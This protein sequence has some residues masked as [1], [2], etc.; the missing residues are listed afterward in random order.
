MDIRLIY[1]SQTGNTRKV[2]EAMEHVFI[3]AGHSARSV[4]MKQ[5]TPEDILQSDVIGVGSPTFTSQ[6]PTPIKRFIKNLPS[7]H[8]KKA[9]VFATSG[10]GP[11]KV[12][13]DMTALLREKG[14]DVIGGTLIKAECFHPAPYVCGCFKGR[15]NEEDLLVVEKFAR[16]AAEH[17]SS[18]HPGTMPESRPDALRMHWSFYEIIGLMNPDFQVRL[19]MPKPKLNESLCTECGVCVQE[20]PMDNITMHPYPEIGNACIRCYRCVN[21]CPQSAFTANWVIAD[22]ILKSLYNETFERWFGELEPGE[23]RR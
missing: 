3:E 8:G 23:K 11:G 7:L 13:Y 21:V 5:A 19:L 14:A 9:F 2:A 1:F 6:A 15:P 4:P 22:I 17:I 10:A 16:A 20:C 18:G 12:L